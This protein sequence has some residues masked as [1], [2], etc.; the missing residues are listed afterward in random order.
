MSKKAIERY[1][2]AVGRQLIC[3]PDTRR[4]LL[5]G[6]RTELGELP[7]E[8]TE[9]LE[10][11]EVHYENPQQTAEELQEAVSPEERAMALKHRHRRF[12]LLGG[13]AVIL[14]LLLA[15]YIIFNYYTAPKYIV[16]DPPIYD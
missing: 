5:K 16:I 9:S 11:L 4:E 8:H 1:C 6:L 15:V 12:L 14:F 7:P 3:L 13:L 2:T 10:K